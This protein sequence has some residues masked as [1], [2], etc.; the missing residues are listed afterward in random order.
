M[1]A[2]VRS[3]QAI[4]GPENVLSEPDTIAGF[5]R[6]W[7]GRFVGDSPAVVRP[8]STDEVAAVVAWCAERGVTVVPQGGNTGL[9][10]GSVPLAGEVVLSLRLLRHLGEVDRRA[11]QVTVGAGVTLEQVQQHAAATGLEVA[12]DLAARGSATVGGMV[13]T[14]AG[15]V[16]A[17]RYGPM[18]A[19]V[20]GIE[21]VLGE[22]AV[23]SHL[24]GLAKDN[25]GY[26]LAGLLCGSEG[27]LAVITRVRLRLV[28]API[29]RGCALVALG[30]V[31][32]ALDCLDSVRRSLELD[33][34]EFFFHNGLELVCRHRAAPMPFA[35]RAAVYLLLEATSGDD[36]AASLAA[37]I[38]RAGAVVADAVIG[39]TPTARA[40]LWAYREAHTEA[41]NAVGVPHK[42]DVAVPVAALSAFCAQVRAE[43]TAL[44]PTASVYLF[45]HIGDGNVHVNVVGAAEPGDSVPVAVDDAVLTLVARMQGSIS[46]EHGI[47]TAKRQFLHLARSPAEVAA[48]VR[49][50]RALDPAGILNPNVL[51]PQ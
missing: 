18:R 38:S 8:R 28:H 13:A 7:T 12:V 27:T 5:V 25:T 19:Q 34:A 42:F 46:A 32:D 33:A 10:G 14:N 45:G 47:G 39:D 6:D 4:V 41:I 2:L 40:A 24:A 26:D 50:K 36:P 17:L 3:L 23:I 44:V 11:R 35:E 29:S 20:A 37:A 15:G 43:V 1:D 21:A 31:D 9:V 48:F 49:I 16:R 22:G 51:L 30:S